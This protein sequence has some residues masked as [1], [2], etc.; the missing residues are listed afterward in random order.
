MLS[1]LFRFSWH[2]VPYFPAALLMAGTG[3]WIC[4]RE[5]GNRI[6]R[7]FHAFTAL[8]ALWMLLLG[9]RMLLTDADAATVLSRYVYAAVLLGLT[10][11]L[12]FSFTVLDTRHERRGMIRLSCVFGIP[13]A[14]CA[15]GTPW[16]VA[17]ALQLPWGFEPRQGA[18]G[19]LFT[20]WV[21]AVIGTLA[22]DAIRACRNRRRGPLHQR[23]VRVFGASLAV[24]FVAAA[25]L[26]TD[27]LGVP[28]YPIGIACVLAFT[29]MTAYVTI[30]HGIVNVTARFASPEFADVMRVGLVILDQDGTVQFINEPSARMLGLRR[31][32]L[33]GQSLGALL[34]K[35][36]QALAAMAQAP[37]DGGS[38]VAY[39]PP[40]EQAPRHLTLSVSAMNDP[41][42]EPTAFVCLMRDV[43]EERRER[44]RQAVA[45]VPQPTREEIDLRQA[46]EKHEFVVHY[47]PVVELKRG[48][49]AG[50]EAL[51]RWR[52][53]HR[54]PLG[55]N[56]FLP[57]A[58]ALGLIGAIDWQV[59]EQACT[60]L[61]RLRAE[62][63]QPALFV[64]VN[65]STAALSNPNLVREVSDLVARCGLAPKD[66]R[67]EL[68]ESTVVID[69]V[70]ETLRGL[71]DAG[72][73]IC[74]DDFGT[75]HS[76]LSRL[77]EAP[78]TTLK[79]DRLF[80][81]EM[82]GGNG[83]KII[84]SIVALANS[85][86]L[87]VIAEGVTSPE[88][89]ALLREMGCGYAQGFLYSPPIG[90][91]QTVAL[92]RGRTAARERRNLVLEARV[93]GE[94]PNARLQSIT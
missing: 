53:P 75:G 16:A 77:H 21:L 71:R 28:V 41:R 82:L 66:V 65:Q 32:E 2:A 27:A 43:T 7:D 44:E 33:V 69:T 70:R 50:F 25:D 83:R 18:L 31:R 63:G 47:Q 3:L 10:P 35:T 23:Q 78:V 81:R 36:P 22:Y 89:V 46:V 91:E 85:L 58:E 5:R 67:L 45:V 38:E 4:R 1:D 49:V 42:G 13:L 26:V 94:M 24:L 86:E 55:P 48:T 93:T 34:G 90:L 57:A 39:Q 61:P 12:Q 8:F 73:G 40:L 51:V 88:Q 76:A 15:V 52:H 20:L 54:G 87:G 56:N 19:P 64:S 6:S 62:T 29:L 80:V 60:D 92:L 30:R 14:L 9:L 11:L 79:I 37:T 74:I 59:L 72:F 68:L 84:G 17:G